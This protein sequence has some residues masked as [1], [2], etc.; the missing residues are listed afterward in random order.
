[1]TTA[2][3][4]RIGL[5]LPF[6]LAVRS[7]LG[8]PLLPKPISISPIL[9]NQQNGLIADN[10][11][12]DKLNVFKKWFPDGKW[13]TGIPVD[14]KI[15]DSL[16]K[17]LKE[18]GELKIRTDSLNILTHLEIPGTE[19][20]DLANLIFSVKRLGAVKSMNYEVK[21]GDTIQFVYTISKGAGMDELEVLE[22]KEVRFT[23]SKTPRNKEQT[24]SFVV[25]ADGV[26]TFNITNK[27]LFTSRGKLLIKKQAVAAKLSF[28][29]SCDT[30]HQVHKEIRTIRDTLSEQLAGQQF[31]VSPRMDITQSHK[32]LIPVSLPPD[33]KILAIG[34]WI[35]STGTARKQWQ[36]IREETADAGPLKRFIQQELLRRSFSPLPEEPGKTLKFSIRDDYGWELRNPSGTYMK[37][38]YVTPSL[39]TRQNYACFLVNKSNTLPQRILIEIENLS[40][41]YI[42]ET[43]LYVEGLVEVTHQEEAEVTTSSCIEYVKIKTI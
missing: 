17:L 27:G 12:S 2:K 42:L 6:L 10:L 33:K 8:Q 40:S 36:A 30:V 1:M 13:D 4:I 26:V 5:L 37:T 28:S 41:L 20:Q 24:G 34:F 18:V 7:L 21:K 32:L 11:H 15:R 23:F 9:K 16:N 39:N 35:G 14:Q 29:Y 19:P 43:E 38:S 3:T 25:A 22:G 31:S